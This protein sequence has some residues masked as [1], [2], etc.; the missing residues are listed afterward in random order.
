MGSKH[1][2]KRVAYLAADKLIVY[3][4]YDGRLGKSFVFE[5]DGDGL[6][7]FGRYLRETPNA[8]FYFLVDVVEEEYRQETLP[9]VFGS[10]RQAMFERKQSRLFRGTPYCHAIPQGRQGEGRR[11]DIVLFTA[12]TNPDLLAPWLG[13]MN[14]HK[15]PLAGVYSLPMM[16]AA[17]LGRYGVKSGYNL[18]VTLHSASGLRQSFFDGLN[19]KISRLAKM[20][21]L[22]TVPFGDYLV[23]E[24][25]KVRRYLNSLRLL[26]TDATLDVYFLSHGQTITELQESI[27]DGD[28]ARY[29]LI[30]L[31]DASKRIGMKEGLSTP[32]ADALFAHLLLKSKTS[33]HYA[34]AAETRYFRLNRVRTAMHAASLMLL[35]GSAIW[36][37]INFIEGMALKEDAASAASKAS[38]YQA[39]YEAARKGLPPTPVSPENL[40]TAVDIAETIRSYKTNPWPMFLTVSQA[41]NGYAMLH[42]DGIDWKAS[43]NPDAPVGKDKPAPQP[44]AAR[45][46][47]E[48]PPGKYRFYQIALVSGHVEPFDGNYRDALQ[49]ID[50]LAAAL[51]KEKNVAKVEV[52]S[53]PLDTSSEATLH[54]S[55]SEKRMPEAPKFALK[56]VLGVGGEKG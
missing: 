27:Q 17:L 13:L 53:M 21:R 30:D 2:S 46:P 9:H 56:V 23:G 38:F 25:E 26:P 11:D 52:V 29:H 16:T 51:R 54:G 41:L 49:S 55:A 1:L 12:L 31:E 24:L 28:Q 6:A 32:Y 39:R 50:R 40:K 15:T 33:N 4:W 10:D 3:H 22:G 18:V 5:A 19:L 36:G 44:A 45:K 34:T 35:L 7:C 14:E 37:G 20:P 8:P 48:Q 42:V 47:A 43:V